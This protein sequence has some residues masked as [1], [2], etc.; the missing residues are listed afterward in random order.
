MLDLTARAAAVVPEVG[1]V[2][3][4]VAI[5]ENGPVLIEGNSLSAGYFAYEHYMLRED[6]MGS[7]AVWEPFVK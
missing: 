7:R 5:A 4:D 2:G 3:W 6:G 1:Y